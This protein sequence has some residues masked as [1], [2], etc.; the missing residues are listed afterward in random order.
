MKLPIQY[1][2][3]T[4]ARAR[5]VPKVPVASELT[6]PPPPRNRFAAERLALIALCSSLIFAAPPWRKLNHNP[7][8][9]HACMRRLQQELWYHHK[10]LRVRRN[11]Q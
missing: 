7:E 8:A 6:T 1:R 11:R 2:P 5:P 3:D 4:S 10:H 9:A